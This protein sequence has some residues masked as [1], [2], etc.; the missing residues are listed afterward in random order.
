MQ[1]L[2]FVM[3]AHHCKSFVS[4]LQVPCV[5]AFSVTVHMLFWIFFLHRGW[6]GQTGRNFLC[7]GE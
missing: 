2:N 4:C 7:R 1:M 6:H 3:F 5:R